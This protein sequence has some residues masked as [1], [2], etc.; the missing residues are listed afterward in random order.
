M[1]LKLYYI[2][3]VTFLTSPDID[4]TQ[5]IPLTLQSSH[6]RNLDKNYLTYKTVDL[7]KL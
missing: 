1:L 7:V 3:D 6:N 5:N 2:A 4:T